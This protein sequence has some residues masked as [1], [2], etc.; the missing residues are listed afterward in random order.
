MWLKSRFKRRF[1]FLRRQQ[2]LFLVKLLTLMREISSLTLT[3][4]FQQRA[5]SLL[6]LILK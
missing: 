1:S 5:T 6:R 3:L 2:L 4:L